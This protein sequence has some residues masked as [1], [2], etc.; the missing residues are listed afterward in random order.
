MRYPCNVFP[1][2]HSSN[3]SVSPRSVGKTSGLL[4]SKPGQFLEAGPRSRRSTCRSRHGIT[5]NFPPGRPAIVVQLLGNRRFRGGSLLDSEDPRKTVAMELEHQR[6]LVQ[7][8]IAGDPQAL[9]QLLLLHCDTVAEHIRPKLAGPLQS[10]V[11]VDDILQE[12]FFR[13]FQ[14][15]Q[16]FEPKSDHSFLAWL[17]TIAESRIVDAIKHQKRRKRGG[18][19]RRVEQPQDQFQTSVIDLMG[20]LA[21]G[22][23]ATPSQIVAT[24]EAVRAMQVAIASLPIEQRDAILLRYFRHQSLEEAAA[25]LDRSPEAIRGLLRRAKQALRRHMQRTSIWFSKR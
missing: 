15:I 7:Q 4:S 6:N 21:D 9:E 1:V 20:V 12:T 24:D 10:L 13:A 14:Q 8:A 16:R 25:E 19:M 2:V 17:K 18:D 23:G 11:S 3:L 22:D 5:E